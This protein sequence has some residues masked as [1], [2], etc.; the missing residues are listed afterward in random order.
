M[1]KNRLI[2]VGSGIKLAAHMTLEAK[3][4]I[5][6]NSCFLYLINDPVLEVWLK[7]LNPNAISLQEFYQG[8]GSRLSIYENIAQKIKEY[9]QDNSEVCVA[10]Y[11]HPGVFCYVAHRAIELARTENFDTLMLPGISAED[12]LFSDI[13]IDPGDYGCQSFECTDFLLRSRRYD[14]YSHLILWQVGM[15]GNLHIAE[16]KI[17]NR[18][19]LK[20]LIEYLLANYPKNH[21]VALY[22]ASIYSGFSPKII[23]CALDNLASQNYSKIST[24]YIPP[25][26]QAKI[27][28]EMA[29]RLGVELV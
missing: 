9:L 10:F 12:C 1:K 8:E 17:N 23:W 13:G 14:Q 4:A 27:D 3:S 16:N 6:N 18:E 22:E 19:N 20:I 21:R 25:L 29:R 5:E 15:I 7:K 26:A 2:I 11:G 24:L 28:P